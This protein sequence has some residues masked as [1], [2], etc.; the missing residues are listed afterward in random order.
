MHTDIIVTLGLL[1]YSLF[2][3]LVAYNKGYNDRNKEI[4]TY[5]EDEMQTVTDLVEKINKGEK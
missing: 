5:I 2:L 4:Q 3:F 1:V